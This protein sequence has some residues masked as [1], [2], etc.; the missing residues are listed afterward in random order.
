MMAKYKFS[1]IL[2]HFLV[3]FYENWSLVAKLYTVPIK[4]AQLTGNILLL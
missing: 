3:K 1:N 4:L 2:V